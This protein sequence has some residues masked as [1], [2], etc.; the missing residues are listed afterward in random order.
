MAIRYYVRQR[1]NPQKPLEPGKW[2]GTK[3]QGSTLTEKE[4]A[5]EISKTCTVKPADIRGALVAIEEVIVEKVLAG[6]S[7]NCGD[8]GTFRAILNG[9]GAPDAASWNPS[10]LKRVKLNFRASK[11]LKF[12]PSDSDV[13][14]ELIQ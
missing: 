8:F 3:I 4:I 11:A 2:Y 14:F 10:Y 5:E 7:V 12:K 13:S 9:E 1:M 6:F